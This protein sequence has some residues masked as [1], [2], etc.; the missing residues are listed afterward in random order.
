MANRV[1]AKDVKKIMNTSIVDSVVDSFIV[2]ANLLVTTHLA[3]ELAETL[4][5]EIEKFLSAHMISI[6]VDRQTVREEIGGD[7]NEQYAKLGLQLDSSTYGQ[8]VKFLDSTG[9]LGNLG[10]KLSTI[11]AVTS[12]ES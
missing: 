4:L 11:V 2:T 9:I 7:T 5:K 10:R 1:D 6:T 8:M 3:G 12:F